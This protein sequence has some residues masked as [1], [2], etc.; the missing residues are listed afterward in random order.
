MI[1][2]LITDR[3]IED[4][5]ALISLDYELVKYI[6]EKYPELQSGYL[7]YFSV[8]DASQLS[9]DYLIM[10]EGVATPD[11]VQTLQQAGKKV[12][13][14]IVNSPESMSQFTRSKVD[15]II[16]DYPKALIQEMAHEALRGD[17]DRIIDGIFF[18]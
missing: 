5:M 16:I 12:I 11:T 8:G 13:V 2:L 9:G 10:E 18:K 7:Y 17:V 1:W 15:G 14:W 6:G 3:A 4:S